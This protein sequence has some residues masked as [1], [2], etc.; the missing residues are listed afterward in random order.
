MEN[1]RGKRAV[2]SREGAQMSLDLFTTDDQSINPY[3]RKII[4]CNEKLTQIIAGERAKGHRI[5]VTI[6]S[7]DGIHEGQMRYMLKAAQ[8]GDFLVVGVDSDQALRRYKI[9]DWRPVRD[10]SRRSELLTYLDFVD[11]VTL[12]DDVTQEGKWEYG[13]L[14]LVKPDVYVA[15]TNS[16]PE[17]QLA[18]ICALCGELVVL[19]PQGVG[20]STTQEILQVVEKRMRKGVDL[21]FDHLKEGKI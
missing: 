7:W 20:I 9:D 11:V 1:S 12:V 13:L 18:E 6:G 17:D 2:R 14:N 10:Q 21:M 8:L 15:V 19:A 16:Y 3:P 4:N 5:V